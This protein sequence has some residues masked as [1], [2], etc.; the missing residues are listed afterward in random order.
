M[1][2]VRAQIFSK[3]V[4]SDLKALAKL[5]RTDKWGAHRYAQHYATHFQSR[6]KK[7]LNVL[8]IGVGGYDN[9]QHGGESLRMWKEYFP[10]SMIYA[11]DIYDKSPHEEDRIKIFRGSQADEAFLQGVVKQTGPLD[12]IIDDG[13]HRNDHVITTFKILFPLLKNGG[14]YAVEDTQTSYWPKMGDDDLGGDIDNPNNLNTTMGFF[15]SLTDGIN[16]EEFLKPGYQPTYFD[17]HIV[18][19]SFYHN[20]IFVHKGLNN[21][22]SNLVEN[23]VIK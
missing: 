9:P 6:R 19:M 7:K 21:E 16:Y 11:I 3:F 22:G 18:S 4:A 17:K 10:R 15:K 5:A 13:S 2:R 20:L 8:E 12:I 1:R 14:I 23:G